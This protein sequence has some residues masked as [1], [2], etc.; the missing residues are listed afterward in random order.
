MN[1]LI[2]FSLGNWHAVIVLVLTMVV[3]GVLSVTAIPI[4]ILPTFKSPIFG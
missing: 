2:R 4:D 1:G 3:L